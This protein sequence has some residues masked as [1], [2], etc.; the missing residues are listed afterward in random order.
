VKF[1]C[2]HPHTGGMTLVVVLEKTKHKK[3]ILKQILQN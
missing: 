3:V 1:W 2:F